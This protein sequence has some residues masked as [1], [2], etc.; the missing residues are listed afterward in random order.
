V[1][2]DTSD[3]QAWLE[4]TLRSL[5]DAVIATDA[6]GR[7]RCLNREATRLTGWEE[8]EARGLPYSEVL[9]LVAV[10]YSNKEIAARLTIS[11]KTVEVHKANAMRKLGLSGRVDLIRYG[12]LQGWLFDT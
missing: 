2:Q 12:V 10:G 4:A 9:R 1:E 6:H 5:S 11:I 8:A 3:E 7:I